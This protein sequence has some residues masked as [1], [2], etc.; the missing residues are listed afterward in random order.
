MKE[1]AVPL[2][3]HVPHARFAQ[4]VHRG[5]I[6]GDYRIPVLR[7]HAQKQRVTGDGGVID[8]D[9]GD[10]ARLIELRHQG[11]DRGRIGGIQYRAAAVVSVRRQRF[12]D[13]RRALRT[14]R[15]ADD[16]CACGPESGGDRAADAARGP[17]D[18]GNLVF[19]HGTSLPWR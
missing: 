8:E 16:A 3:H 15:R 10:L 6:G 13:T 18:E 2:L 4:A 9:R 17:A 11:I 1:R 5:E 14:G 7:L 12:A 19:K